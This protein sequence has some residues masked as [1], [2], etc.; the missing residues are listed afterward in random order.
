M[1]CLGTMS[2]APVARSST[3]WWPSGFTVEHAKSA[4]LL[5]IALQ[6]VGRWSRTL[7]AEGVWRLWALAK[8]AVLLRVFRLMMLIP[9]N[10]QR[11]ER[12]MAAAMSDISK[13]LMPAS[14]VPT[15]R[16][17]PA[18]GRD[19]T[20]VQAQLD[21]LQRLGAHGEADGRNVYLDGQVSG[22]VYHGGEE[23][24]RVT[25]S[26]LERFLLTNPL[27]PEV[28]PGLRKMESEVVAMVLSMFHA[29]TGA[30]GTTTSGGTE[31]IMMACLAMREWGRAER[32]ITHAE[33]VAPASAHVA[34]DKAAHYFGMTIRR[35]AVDRITRKVD[36]HAMQRAINANTVLLVGSAPNFPDGII[37]DIVAIGS[38]AKRYHIGCHVDCCLGSFLVPF[39]EAAGYVSEPFDFRVDGV[40]SISCDTHKYG[41]A[42]KGSSIV[43]YH[44]EALRRY[45]YFVSTDW[46]GGVY[47]SPTLAGSRA[48]AL[49]AG[50]WAVMTRLGRDGYIQS[51]R[52][53]VG[54]AKEIEKRVRAEIPELVVLGK[55]LVSVVA[56]GSAGRVNIYDV[57]DQM[58]RRGWHL[59]A[60]GGEIPAFHIACTRLTVPVVGRFI[61]DLK[62]SVADSH[63]K[64]SKSGAMATVYGLHTTTPVAP[65]LLRE[66]A[67][68]YIDTMY[69]VD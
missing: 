14:T 69:K 26:S 11:V 22:T 9:S 55:P 2:P 24:N 16:E 39:L 54:A 5:L 61:D 7:R 60:I 50:A 4:V 30:A 12:E 10:R 35:V 32:G 34:F 65:M 29:P 27:H 13:S 21:A 68:R 37:D 51:C 47:A 67:S 57:G 15:M 18:H 49:I 45:Q 3:G 31:S 1:A 42:P 17:L 28:F 64:P 33:I 44:T 52:E 23:L 48:G 63:T 59:N 20:W 38:L 43:M 6:Y 58:S 46:V 66:M 53:I 36:I 62:A 19:A 41:F 8:Q 40:T 56:F 25:L